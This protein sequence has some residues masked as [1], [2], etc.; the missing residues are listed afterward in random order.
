MMIPA[1]GV[2]EEEINKYAAEDPAVVSG[3]LVADVRPWLVG[4]SQ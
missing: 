4:M 2:T 3:L 1:G